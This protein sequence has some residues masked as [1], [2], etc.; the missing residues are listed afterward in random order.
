M[1]DLK[2]SGESLSDATEPSDP[3]FRVPVANETDAEVDATRIK[4]AVQAAFS[5]SPYNDVLVSI[6]IV[7]DEAIHEL[8]RQFLDHDYATDVL[9]FPLEDAPPRLEGEIVVSI[10]TAHRVAA[11]AGWTAGEELLLYVIH[12]ALHLVGYD[13]KKLELASEMRA[14]ER[15]VLAQLGIAIPAQDSRWRVADQEGQGS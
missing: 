4:A 15:A 6:A 10:D 9:S 2:S 8:N 3:T 1:P 5:G 13:D 14:R 11:E 7:D 12:G